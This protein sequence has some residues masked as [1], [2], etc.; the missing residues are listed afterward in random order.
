MQ[1]STRQR[2]WFKSSN[3]MPLCLE[4]ID[5]HISTG[6]DKNDEVWSYI[7]KIFSIIFCWK[8]RLEINSKAISTIFLIL[9]NPRIYFLWISHL[10]S[11]FTYMNING[12]SFKNS[13]SFL[14]EVF[15][16]SFWKVSIKI[17]K[18]LSLCKNVKPRL[19][20]ESYVSRYILKRVLLFL[21]CALRARN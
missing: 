6:L 16:I 11:N 21:H 8:G 20:R 10:T 14:I 15:Y 2:Q 9:K 7:L 17:L 12:N 4:F 1:N 18:K 3:N 19:R 13:E 5:F